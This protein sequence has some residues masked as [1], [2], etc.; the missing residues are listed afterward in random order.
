MAIEDHCL[1]LLLQ[2]SMCGADT[3]LYSLGWVAESPHPI[4]LDPTTAPRNCVVWDS[5]M[6]S[7]DFVPN[8]EIGRLTNPHW[9]EPTS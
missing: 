2:A 8:D 3:T 4:A 7:L 6:D 9:I 1:N 5:L